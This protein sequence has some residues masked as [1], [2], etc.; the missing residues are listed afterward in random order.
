LQNLDKKT[1]VKA[2]KG[3]NWMM[4]PLYASGSTFFLEKEAIAFFLGM[5]HQ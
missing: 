1:P 5:T 2:N 4:L 3:L